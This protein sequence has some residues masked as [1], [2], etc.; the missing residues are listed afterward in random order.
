MRVIVFRTSLDRKNIRY[1]R[2]VY[3]SERKRVS[4]VISH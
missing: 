2:I 4:E 1:M 3:D